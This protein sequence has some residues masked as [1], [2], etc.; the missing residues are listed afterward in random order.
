MHY[1]LNK[2][3]TWINAGFLPF[4]ICYMLIA[5]P[6]CVYSDSLAFPLLRTIPIA[7]HLFFCVFYFFLIYFAY[8]LG[9]VFAQS[10]LWRRVRS[11]NQEGGAILYYIFAV[12]ALVSVGT[13]IYQALTA[14]AGYASGGFVGAREEF[15]AAGAGILIRLNLIAVPGL[16]YLEKDIK[17]IRAILIVF[18]VLAVVRAFLMSERMA[19]LEYLLILFVV[20][21]IKNI[22]PKNKNV[23]FILTVT[24]LF[25]S[26]IQLLRFLF[27]SEIDRNLAEAGS[28]GVL[29]LFM[30][31]YA[32]TQNKFYQLFF[33]DIEYPY[34]T[35][36]A[37]YRALLYGKDSLREYRF[38][39]EMAYIN[40]YWLGALNNP[41][42]MAQDYSDFGFFGGIASIFLK[43]AFASFILKVGVRSL[44]LTPFVV[45]MMIGVVEYPR[46][47]YLYAPFAFVL[48]IAAMILMVLCVV[49]RRV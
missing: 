17:K 39:D 47:N 33:Y 36:S 32:D 11:S 20:L 42:G 25:F 5:I 40:P 31:Y 22:V 14:G 9:S 6:Y 7:Y 34:T 1:F 13:H 2:P 19:M 49:F 26:L 10:F 23:I 29:N 4:A 15:S 8:Q 37:F 45:L 21:R 12:V 24:A 41:G 43:F 38:F 3:A 48:F 44:Y 18:G 35:W 28:E 27:Q 16:C 46:F 30:I